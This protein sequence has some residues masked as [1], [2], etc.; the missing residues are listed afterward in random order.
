[1]DRLPESFVRDALEKAKGS[2]FMGIPINQLTRDELIAMAVSGWKA[3]EGGMEQGKRD[4]EFLL[5]CVRAK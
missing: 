2:L 3:W 1:M 5:D 4:R